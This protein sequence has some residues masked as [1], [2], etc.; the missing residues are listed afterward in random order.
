MLEEFQQAFPDIIDPVLA[1]LDD[2]LDA[3]WSE[4]LTS[5]DWKND[6]NKTSN[7][8]PLLLTASY[9]IFRAFDE[10]YGLGGDYKY[11]LGHSLGEYTAL[12]AAGVLSFR[13]A[14]WMVRQRG[15]A[16]EA[17]T[18]AFH[19][20]SGKETAM[21][22]V[23]FGSGGDPAEIRSVLSWLAKESADVDVGNINSQKQL[24]LSGVKNTI[25]EM[26]VLDSRGV[27][28]TLLTTAWIV[29]PS[30]QALVCGHAT[31]MCRGR[32]I[33]ELWHT[34]RAQWKRSLPAPWAA[35]FSSIGHQKCR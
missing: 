7:A 23:M 31:S 20:Q 14:V 34:V 21:T 32:F 24:V 25:K 35:K 9:A 19:A 11:F 13:D 30:K 3:N 29:H 5:Y 12:V 27:Y 1:E 4:A 22:T 6:V 26:Y 10:M 15:K 18:N 2:S 28:T 8:Q 17:A 16:M 33:R